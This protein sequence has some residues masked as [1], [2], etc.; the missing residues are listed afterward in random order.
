M[1][2]K[3]QWLRQRSKRLIGTPI[4]VVGMLVA[5]SIGHG[6]R[7]LAAGRSCSSEPMPVVCG[8]SRIWTLASYRRKKVA[9]QLVDAMR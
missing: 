2:S 9:S 6:Y 7:V 3:E 4:K 8:V 1:S 5:E